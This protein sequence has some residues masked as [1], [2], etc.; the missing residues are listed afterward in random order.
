MEVGAVS[1]LFCSL[2]LPHLGVGSATF[3]HWPHIEGQDHPN[4]IPSVHTRARD[5]FIN[6]NLLQ[7][8]FLSFNI[9]LKC[10]LK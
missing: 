1:I 6:C 9:Y 8:L 4:S 3:N 7:I 10:I 2:D 5:H